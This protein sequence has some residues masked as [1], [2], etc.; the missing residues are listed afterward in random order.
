MV[1]CK[2]EEYTSLCSFTNIPYVRPNN[3]FQQMIGDNND[4]MLFASRDKSSDEQWL[5]TTHKALV[6][7]FKFDGIISVMDTAANPEQYVRLMIIK[8]NAGR[9]PGVAF[10]PRRLM[11]QKGTSDSAFPAVLIPGGAPAPTQPGGTIGSTIPGTNIRPTVHNQFKPMDYTYGK[12]VWMKTYKLTRGRQRRQ[13]DPVGADIVA[14]PPPPGPGN[15]DPL[16]PNGTNLAGTNM[17]RVGSRGSWTRVK[18]DYKIM[19][20]FKW[21]P[22]EIQTTLPQTNPL[23]QVD[24]G[25]STVQPGGLDLTGNTVWSGANANYEPLYH[26]YHLVAFPYTP[27]HPDFKDDTADNETLD[28]SSPAYISGTA[29]TMFKCISR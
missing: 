24:A 12:P 13:G 29:C 15:N 27:I 3:V 8:W 25:G 26:Q 20:K 2:D 22:D 16:L 18:I 17:D 1:K 6:T 10:D 4:V 28:M 7:R 14:V 5:R 23:P 11:L 19:K 21:S 9:T